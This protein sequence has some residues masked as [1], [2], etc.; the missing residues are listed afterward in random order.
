MGRTTT[1]VED[2][3]LVTT[4]NTDKQGRV[5]LGSDFKNGKV[6]IVVESIEEDE[7]DES[8]FARELDR[9]SGWGE[10]DDYANNPG[11]ADDL[12]DLGENA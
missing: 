9:R 7:R 5:Y 1:T 2:P 3:D 10:D 6:R 12:E 4:K 11:W 8:A